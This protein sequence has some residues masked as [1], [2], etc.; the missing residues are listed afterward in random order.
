MADLK[1]FVVTTREVIKYGEI[2]EYNNEHPDESMRYMRYG[3]FSDDGDSATFIDPAGTT[4]ESEDKHYKFMP[5]E[6]SED[7]LKTGYASRLFFDELFGELE[8]SGKGL[9]IFLHGI[10][11]KEKKEH[12][13]VH[14]LHHAYVENSSNLERILM[15]T[16]P[17]QG[18]AATQYPVEKKEDCLRTGR[19]LALFFLKLATEIQYRKDNNLYVP[20]IYFMPQS[21]G[22]RVVNQMMNFLK[23][24]KAAIYDRVRMLFKM[25]ILMSPDMPSRSLRQ[26]TANKFDYKYI[27]ELA[28]HTCIFYSKQDWVLKQGEQLNNEELL[29]YT[30][31]KE[32]PPEICSY[33][34][35]QINTP[36]MALDLKRTRAHRYFQYHHKVISEIN[37]LFAG[38][39]PEGLIELEINWKNNSSAT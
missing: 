12:Q 15:I 3:R 29:G 17:S 4:G 26:K 1:H 34:I 28:H 16:W 9:L 14:L 36:Q 33:N 8:T 18:F 5:K 22:H 38:K 21:M 39:I 24:Q 35:K 31:P 32:H 23:Y 30:G 37:E 11:V 13:H 27:T 2:W 25:I 20:E 7:K 19:A 10:S 6:L